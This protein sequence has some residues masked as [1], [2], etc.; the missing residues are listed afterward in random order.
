MAGGARCKQVEL[1]LDEIA[2][3]RNAL[4]RANP[5]DLMVIC[6]DKH[7]EVMSEL[8]NWSKQ[9]QAGSGVHPDAPSADPD[10]TPADPVEAGTST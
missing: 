1:V 6:V 4:I 5:G 9:A 7:A 3:V 2:A 10:Y 8:E